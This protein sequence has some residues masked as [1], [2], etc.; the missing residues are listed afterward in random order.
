V[1]SD[2]IDERPGFHDLNALAGH[3][4][5]AILDIRRLDMELAQERTADSS[6][7]QSRHNLSQVVGIVSRANLVQALSAGLKEIE[8]PPTVDDLVMREKLMARCRIMEPI[9]V[10]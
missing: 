4:A 5:D 7:M 8:A 9:L 1:G 6:R 2:Q 3:L 10:G